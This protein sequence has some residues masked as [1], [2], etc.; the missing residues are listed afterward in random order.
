MEIKDA[1]GSLLYPFFLQH[2]SITCTK[3]AGA[4]C[5]HISS[6]LK[7]VFKE[8]MDKVHKRTAALT[9]TANLSGFDAS[10]N[11]R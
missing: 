1:G 6:N 5:W 7:N 10:I 3:A 9:S 2:R 8:I 11:I 4:L